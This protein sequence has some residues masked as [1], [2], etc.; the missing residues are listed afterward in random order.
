M[1]QDS[2]PG[3][4]SRDLGTAGENEPAGMSLIRAAVLVRRR[5]GENSADHPACG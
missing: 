2:D 1:K 4:P 5:P 3:R